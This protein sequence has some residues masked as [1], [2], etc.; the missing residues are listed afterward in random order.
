MIRAT[1]QDYARLLVAVGSQAAGSKLD[2]AV[3]GVI[4]LMRQ[5]GDAHLVVKLPK[6][7]EELIASA[8]GGTVRVTTAIETPELA[9]LVAKAL[10]RREEEVHVDVDPSVIAGARVQVGHTLIDA[11]LDGLLQR[12]QSHL[13]HS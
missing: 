8:E 7:L 5:R 3:G 2:A 6:A 9:T 12:L 1:L 10:Q 13:S 11:S 4:T